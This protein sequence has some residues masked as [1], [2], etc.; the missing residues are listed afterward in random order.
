VQLARNHGKQILNDTQQVLLVRLA[1][2]LVQLALGM[3]HY[4]FYFLFL[5]FLIL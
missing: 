2:R 5:L 4:V 3:P 1:R